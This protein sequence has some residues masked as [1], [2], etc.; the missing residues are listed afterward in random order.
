M[1]KR[2][3]KSAGGD[4]RTQAKV[5]DLRNKNNRKQN[6]RRAL[7][8]SIMALVLCCAMLIGTTFAWFTDSVV[9]GKNKIV[10]G[11]LD[12]ELKYWDGT[13]WKDVQNTTELF[14]Q[15]TLWEPGHTEIVYLQIHN[16][17]TLALDYK[18]QVY[19]ETETLGT[20]QAGDAFKLSEYLKYGIAS[21]DTE[22][23]DLSRDDARAV[24]V[25]GAFALGEYPISAEA[26]EAGTEKYLALAV[27]MPEEVGNEANYA[28]GTTPP[29]VDLA[30]RLEA[31]QAE[32]EEDSFGSDYDRFADGT[33]DHT[34]FGMTVETVETVAGGLKTKVGSEQSETVNG[35]QVIDAGGIVVTYADGVKTD[36]T[37]PAGASEGSDETADAMQGLV[38]TGAESEYSISVSGTEKLGVYELTLPV[39]QDNT[40]L[41]KIVKN[42]G[43][44]QEI[45]GVYHNGT[46]LTNGEPSSDDTVNGDGGYYQYDGATGNLVIWVLHASEIT[47]KY[48]GLFEGGSGTAA[49]PFLIA[50]VQQL[51]NINLLQS[52]M[53][54]G[55]SYYFKQTA[56]IT[57]DRQGAIVREFCGTYDGGGYKIKKT[58]TGYLFANLIGHAAVKNVTIIM[59]APVS[60]FW[61]A[62]WGTAYG[63]DFEN[64]TFDTEPSGKVISCNATNYGLVVL[65]ALYTSGDATPTYNFKNITNH[66]SLQNAGTCTGVFVGSGPC[67]N[68][69][70]TVNYINCKNT[71]DITGSS[72]VGLLYGNYAYIA[73]MAESGS[74]IYVSGCSNTGTLTALNANGIAALAPK[75][76]GVTGQTQEQVG[77]NYVSGNSLSSSDITIKQSNDNFAVT[78]AEDGTTYRMALNVGAEYWTL[79]GQAWEDSDTEAVEAGQWSTVANVSNGMKYMKE[80]TANANVVGNLQSF[81]AY[82][83]VTAVKQNVLTQTEA[84]SLTF[85]GQYTIVVKGGKNYMIIDTDDTYY[86]NSS[87]SVYLYAYD[88]AGVLTGTKWIQ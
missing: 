19:A 2:G 72:T 17:G 10:A 39:A 83:K 87:V 6:T 52:D 82:D 25:S 84:D 86:I 76:D 88:S 78:S 50:D 11:N 63:A 8:S 80:I 49:D 32:K 67:F 24:A 44:G 69:K 28:A 59:D 33:P 81:Y 29:T 18:M 30:I 35:E 5:T 7:L 34:E 66:V 3:R 16:A 77:G 48:A 9:S 1:E 41:V 68:T 61:C 65:N 73:T 15:D 37:A 21:Y 62:D 13:G 53:E 36:D 22:T 40:V 46:A 45:N 27:Y 12:V 70:T 23:K 47:V 43:A 31:T 58:Q 20:N 26:M 71:G 79:D 56:D 42:I 38:Y 75:Y 54:A 74:T 55:R 64:I 4:G 85:S 14:E 57:D 51:R 60:I